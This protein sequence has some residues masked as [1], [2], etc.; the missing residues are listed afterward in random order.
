MT[1]HRKISS[2]KIEQYEHSGVERLN[3]PPVGLV[4]PELDPVEDK[5]VYEYDPHLDPKLV[6]AGKVERTS[7]EVDTVSLHVHE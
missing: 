5:K 3:N 4:T 6:W 7:F 2:K 1:N